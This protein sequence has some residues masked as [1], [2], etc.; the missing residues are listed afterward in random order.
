MYDTIKLVSDGVVHETL[1]RDELRWPAAW[2]WRPD[3][4]PQSDPP[5]AEWFVGAFVISEGGA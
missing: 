4:K 5:L 3:L 1:D 2:A